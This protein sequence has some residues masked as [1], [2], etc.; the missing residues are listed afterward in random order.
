MIETVR[1]TCVNT[2]TSKDVKI[3]SSLE[4]LIDLFGVESPIY[5]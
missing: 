3:G 4:E 2:N 5:S 1:V